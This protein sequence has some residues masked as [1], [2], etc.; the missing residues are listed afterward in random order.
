MA[1][2]NRDLGHSQQR[3]VVHKVEKNLATGATTVICNIPWPCSLDIAQFSCVGVSGSPFY[4]LWIDRFIVGTG[5]TN[6]SVGTSTAAVAFGTSGLPVGGIS[7]IIGSTTFTFQSGDRLSFLSG[8]SNA[9]V[10]NIAMTVVLRPIN[11]ILKFFG[12]V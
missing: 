5:A 8:G 12:S 10:D 9:A 6:F 7:T 1:I 11:D 3:Q 2:I 4:T